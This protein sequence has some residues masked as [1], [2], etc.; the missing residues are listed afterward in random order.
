MGNTDG[1]VGEFVGRYIT[2]IIGGVLL[3]GH[4]VWL[5]CLCIY[6]FMHLLI[7]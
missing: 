3:S 2:V 7:V 1:N 4:T 6:E 5:M